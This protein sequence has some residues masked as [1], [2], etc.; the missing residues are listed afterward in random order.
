MLE[1]H[2]LCYIK[3]REQNMIRLIIPLSFPFGVQNTDVPLDFEFDSNLIRVVPKKTADPLRFRVSLEKEITVVDTEINHGGLIIP[4][5][6][7]RYFRS[8]HEK[9]ENLWQVV[10][11]I[12]TEISPEK[13]EKDLKFLIAIFLQGVLNIFGY[14]R[15]SPI[16][17]NEDGSLLFNS[18]LANLTSPGQDWF[19][20]SNLLQFSLDRKIYDQA[21]ALGG[22]L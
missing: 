4:P 7:V 3:I 22:G 21:A 1:T 8:A 16:I 12:D 19:A 9:P 13:F 6:P 5:G 14:A 17:Q 10:V 15:V 20:L 2:R 11:E 18:Q